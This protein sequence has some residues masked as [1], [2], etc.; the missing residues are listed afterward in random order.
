MAQNRGKLRK[1][2][3]WLAQ[4]GLLQTAPRTIFPNR[5]DSPVTGTLCGRKTSAFAREYSVHM[6]LLRSRPAARK[7]RAA[8]RI[9]P[10][11]SGS[12]WTSAD[13][14]DPSTHIFEHQQRTQAGMNR[15]LVGPVTQRQI[16]DV[17][18]DPDLGVGRIL[19]RGLRD[20]TDDH[21]ANL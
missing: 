1:I 6:F 11:E 5:T 21:I 4:T 7:D 8:G 15:H 3:I 13:L 20:S 12:D 14:G 17:V 2:G 16:T 19:Q 10:V 9:K 18:A